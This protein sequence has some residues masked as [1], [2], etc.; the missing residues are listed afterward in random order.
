MNCFKKLISFAAAA[1][2]CAA[3]AGSSA[4]FAAESGEPNVTVSPV[5]SQLG[6]SAVRSG[7]SVTVS[8]DAD[9]GTSIGG[10][11]VTTFDND[12]VKLDRDSVTKGKFTDLQNDALNTDIWN[13]V[14]NGISGTDIT[15]FTYTLPN[16][17]ELGTDY[18]FKYHFGELY[19]A[20]LDGLDL[21]EKDVTVT[22]RETAA[23]FTVT[24]VSNGVKVAEQSVEEGNHAAAEDAPVREGYTFGGWSA[25][26]TD[27]FDFTTAITADLTLNALWTKETAA[28][29]KTVDLSKVEI[30][31]TLNANTDLDETF[32]FQL[33]YVGVTPTESGAKVTKAPSID[34][35]SV[36]KSGSV[37]LGSAD[38]EIGGVYEFKV[39]EVKGS[40]A[41]MEYD[42]TEYTLLLEIEE[43]KDGNLVLDKVVVKDGDE[44]S[45]LSFENNYAPTDTLTVRKKVEGA[46]DNPLNQEKKFRFSIVFTAPAV[47]NGQNVKATLN[48]AEQELVYGTAFSFTL[49]D[50]ES[51]DFTNIPEGAAYTLTET[52]EEY[53]TGS[54]EII[55]GETKQTQNGEYAKD[56]T[57]SGIEITDGGNEANVTNTY[58]IT[59]PTGMQLSHEMLAVI[60]L[61]LAAAA[62]S[63][64]LNRKLRAGKR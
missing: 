34:P 24:F 62:G 18:A 42:D 63:F 64:I 55:S 14:S 53:Y 10:M 20:N 49:G 32:T 26:G 1:M 22:Y 13:F 59:P 7:D 38:F 6:F 52:G 46:D 28:G 39:T 2:L 5:S 37:K 25:N 56:L 17:F 12:L 61:I 48:G 43:D 35:V 36:T 21:E 3:A 8:F 31:K 30:T 58:S 11:S 50:G 60:A 19:D 45:D 9:L 27:A 57:L 40:T 33:E 23:E 15:S 16:G 4:A 29:N 44:K 51:L 47:T 54:A 41:G